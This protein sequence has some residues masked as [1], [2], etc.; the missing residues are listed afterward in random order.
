MTPA[1]C[2]GFDLQDTSSP[3]E[4]SSL[5]GWIKKT[6]TIVPQLYHS[7]SSTA[8]SADLLKVSCGSNACAQL[9]EEKLILIQRPHQS[10]S[11]VPHLGQ[12]HRGSDLKKEALAPGEGSCSHCYHY[13]V[14]MGLL[15]SV[16]NLCWIPLEFPMNFYIFTSSP[17]LSTPCKFHCASTYHSSSINI[18][19]KTNLIGDV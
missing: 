5:T 6:T 8:V 11:S 10:F 18:L 2:P 13:S 16:C 12:A 3:P 7:S 15:H 4:A 9:G 14:L 1:T 19:N 17:Q